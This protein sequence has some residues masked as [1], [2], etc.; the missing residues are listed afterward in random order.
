MICLLVCLQIIFVQYVTKI[1]LF[2]FEHVI[3]KCKYVLYLCTYNPLIVRVCKFIVLPSVY[4]YVHH[5]LWL[6]ISHFKGIFPRKETFTFHILSSSPYHLSLHLPPSLLPSISPPSL[7][8]LSLSV[9]PSQSLSP[10]ISAHTFNSIRCIH[11]LVQLYHNVAVRLCCCF[12]LT[13]AHSFN[14]KVTNDS[15]T[16]LL[17][18][19]GMV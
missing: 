8:S 11:F 10:S 18:P 1:T 12:P 15:I 2:S 19:R 5:E 17:T 16:C 13:C 6:F 9:P 3:V 14:T 7:I 4:M